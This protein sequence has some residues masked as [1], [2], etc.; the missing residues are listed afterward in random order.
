MW[1]D[2]NHDGISQPAELATLQ[3]SRIL[4]ISLDYKKSNRSDQYGNVLRFL[5][6]AWKEGR[7]GVEKP[8]LTWDVFFLKEP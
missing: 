7:D 5:G 4:R 2:R 3:G 6:R 1:T 8:I